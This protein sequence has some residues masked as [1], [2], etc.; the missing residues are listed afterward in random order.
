MFAGFPRNLATEFRYPIRHP[1]WFHQEWNKTCITV[2][3][4]TLGNKDLLHTIEL[5][6][7]VRNTVTLHTSS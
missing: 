1:L 3:I 4:F 7:R 6:Q 2:D 5:L